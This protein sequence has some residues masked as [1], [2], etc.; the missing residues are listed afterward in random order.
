M[1]LWQEAPR[2]VLVVVEGAQRRCGLRCAGQ[3]RWSL[4]R[5]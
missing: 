5:A 1:R 2:F 3:A 4:Q